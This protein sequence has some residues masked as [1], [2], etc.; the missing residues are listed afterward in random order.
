MLEI[1]LVLDQNPGLWIAACVLFGLLVGSFLNVVISRLPIMMERSWKQE[2]AVLLEQPLAPHEHFDLVKPRSQCPRCG[3]GISAWQNIPLL[4]YLLLRGRCANCSNPIS[5]QYPL[6]EAAAGLLAGLAAA[7]YGVS[8]A[9][10]AAIGLALTLLPLAVIDFHT[11]LLPDSMVLP[12]LWFGL[13]ANLFEIFVPLHDAVVGAM[14]G[15]LSLWLVY[16]AFRLVTGKEGM[17]Y[18]DFKLLA[19]LGAWFGWQLLPW[20]I[21]AASCVGA[22]LGILLM[23]TKKLQQGQAMPFGPFLAGAGLVVLFGRDFIGTW[24]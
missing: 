11:Q 2:C 20:I 17:G 10:I 14:A 4:S 5:M 18:G 1:I 15:Y 12:L 8:W 16:H 23:V 24:P 22:S 21:L 7:H 13:F 3:H 19:A 9:A 6:V